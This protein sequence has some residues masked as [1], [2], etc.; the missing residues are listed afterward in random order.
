MIQS[1]HRAFDILEFI[2]ARRGEPAPLG[3]IAAATGLHA[4]TCA[5]L[6]K[7]LVTRSYVD[8]RG[9]RQ[10]Y[11]LGPMAQVLARAGAYRADL[12]QLAEPLLQALAQDVQ[13]NIV[14]SALHQDHL[15]ELARA[16][17]DSVLQ[18]RRDLLL[19]EN[20]Y[21]A[22]NGRLLLAHLAPAALA[23][24]VAR[25]GLPGPDW[26]AATDLEALQAL[27]APVRE[28]GTY[29]DTR[30]DGVARVSYPVREGEHVIAALGLYAPAMR[31]VGEH[32]DRALRALQHTAAEI[33]RAA[34]KESG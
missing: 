10:G 24:L 15:F 23:E 22:A 17:G 30:P 13:E 27:L 7:T 9:P 31:F 20:V 5:N 6:L 28:Q 14:L 29:E 11:V 33:S 4:S 1:L 18:L 3:E 8:Q 25:R 21:R 34:A 26:P 32:R 16:E 2:A 19:V 12:V